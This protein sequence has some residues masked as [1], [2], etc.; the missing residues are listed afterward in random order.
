MVN[1]ATTSLT[2]Q[3]VAENKLD[4]SIALSIAEIK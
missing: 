4:G 3:D 2:N 1:G